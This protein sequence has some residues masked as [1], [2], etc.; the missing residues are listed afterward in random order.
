MH[1]TSE[2]GPTVVVRQMNGTE[3][4]VFDQI[5]LIDDIC[6]ELIRFAP[7][8]D[9][10]KFRYLRNEVTKRV[11]GCAE[12]RLSDHDTVDVVLACFGIIRGTRH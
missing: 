11:L 8:T 3:S 12:Y 6:E 9:P 7:H 4:I 5:Q 2:E 10:G 1:A